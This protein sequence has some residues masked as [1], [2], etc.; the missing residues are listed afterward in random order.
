M[1]DKDNLP[2]AD[3]AAD[4]R[5]EPPLITHQRN[6]LAGLWAAELMGLIGHAASD[7]TRTVIHTDHPPE[8]EHD[9][10]ADKVVR[11]LSQDLQ[12]RVTIGEIREKMS[13]FLQEAK[14]QLLH[15]RRR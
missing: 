10:D 13:H 3:Q 2:A 12:G 11:K 5:L 14:R 8:T 4:L 6:R 1:G 15:E 9:D 7:Y